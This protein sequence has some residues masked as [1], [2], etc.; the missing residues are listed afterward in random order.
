[1][2]LPN[3]IKKFVLASLTV[4]T[5]AGCQSLSLKPKLS[6]EDSIKIS[7][8]QPNPISQTREIEQDA[9]LR[10][11][12]K[13]KTK[14][15]SPNFSKAG[16]KLTYENFI[17]VLQRNLNKRIEEKINDDLNFNFIKEYYFR[18]QADHE[19]PRLYSRNNH[20]AYLDQIL[21]LDVQNDFKS[22]G[23]RAATETITES[24][25][26]RTVSGKV[27]EYT[28]GFFEIR[29]AGSKK[30]VHQIPIL[31]ES[32]EKPQNPIEDEF[33]DKQQNPQKYDDKIS[34]LPE[35][36]KDLK[37]GIDF[38]LKSSGKKEVSD[39]FPRISL[40]WM[41]L[42][43]FRLDLQ[44]KEIESSFSLSGGDFGFGINSIMNYAP[45]EQST[46]SIGASYL[47]N[48]KTILRGGVSRN[49]KEEDSSFYMEFYTKF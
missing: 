2:S 30:F 45:Y 36:I 13:E 31:D 20:D 18:V 24:A 15:N 21:L 9:F 34:F 41:N 17:S 48:K 43:R 5:M 6:L 35:K 11:T 29:Y 26:H 32:Y 16:Y 49:F 10:G 1:M 27:N 47:I 12:L 33:Y 4:L 25:I 44:K 28:F 39:F 3:K 22:L 14:L 46:T 23:T 8:T 40:K 42:F 38:S 7:N 37:F 19:F